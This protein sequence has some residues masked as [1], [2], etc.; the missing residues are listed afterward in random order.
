MLCDNA[1]RQCIIFHQFTSHVKMKSLHKN[2]NSIPW[3]L[4]QNFFSLLILLIETYFLQ[5]KWKSM[6][7]INIFLF[8]VAA[9][10]PNVETFNPT[11]DTWHIWKHDQ[12]WLPRRIK[13]QKL[14]YQIRTRSSLLA[15]EVLDS[16]TF[17]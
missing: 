8:V 6:S 15:T 7:D 9:V 2:S 1:V 3:G 13:G 10:F 12:T 14:A 11:L 16:W 4:G 17:R 5:K